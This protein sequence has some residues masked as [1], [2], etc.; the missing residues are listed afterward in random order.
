[1]GRAVAVVRRGGELLGECSGRRADGPM[2]TAAFSD[3]NNER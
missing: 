3:V 2:S 1:M